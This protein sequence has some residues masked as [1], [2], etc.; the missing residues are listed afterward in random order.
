MNRLVA[1]AVVAL[2]AL[3]LAACAEEEPT[4][5]SADI[6]SGFLAACSQPLEDT[7]LIGDICQCVFDE[8]RSAIVFSEFTALDAELAE[9]REQTLPTELTEIIADCVLDEADL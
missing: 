3:G 4:E 2:G 5:F 6:R 1:V 8:T 7:R 9:D